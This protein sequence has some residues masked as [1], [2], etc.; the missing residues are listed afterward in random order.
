MLKA[1][2]SRGSPRRTF[3]WQ[4][5]ALVFL[6]VL[7]FSLQPSAFSEDWPRF[8]GPRGNGVSGESGLLEKWPTNGPPK[9][10]WKAIGTGYSAPSILDGNLVLHHRVRDEEIVEC[11]DP[12]SGNSKWRYAYPSQFIDPYGYN[13]GPRS[14]PLLTSNRC[15]TLGA[16][17]KLLCLDMNGKLAWQRDT[18][19]EFTIPPAFFGVGST[20]ILEGNLLIVM[21]GGQ[22]NS[23]VVAFDAATGKTVWE[24]VGQKNWEGQRM[25]GFPGEPIIRWPAWEKQ[26]SYSTPVAATIHGQRHVLCVTRQGLVSVSPTN[27]EVNFSFW[28]RSILRDSVNAMSPVVVGDLIFISGAYQKVGSVLLRVKPDGKSVEEAWRSTV[29]EIHWNTPIYNDGYLYAF[30]GRNEPDARFRCVEFKTGKLMWDRDES[31]PSHSMM[32]PPVYG[33]G[34]AILAEGRLIVL[35]EGGL[36]GLFKLNPKEPEEICRSQISELHHPCWA[37]PILSNKKLYLRSEDRLVCFDLAK[38]N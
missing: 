16:E 1:K 10:W 26:A 6:V 23:G 33:R 13:N 3:M 27:G 7:A 17:G 18:G 36:L 14:S 24:S 11:L 8:L 20:P 29:L 35:G 28:F 30:S 12:A 15:Y 37:A 19:S 22:T 21:V 4:P 32:Q 34:S 31:F 2:A 25:I 9:I 38:R 5:F